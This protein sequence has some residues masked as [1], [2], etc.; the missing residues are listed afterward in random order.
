MHAGIFMGKSAL[1]NVQVDQFIRDGFLRIDRAFS[2]K[3]A[4][5]CC[6]LLWHQIPCDRND[7]VTW[8]NPVI[9]IPLCHGE[10]FDRVT[11]TPVLHEAF[12]LLVGT[13]RWSVRQGL[14]SFIVRF[15]RAEDPLD[16]PVRWHVDASFPGESSDPNEQHDYSAW[17]A[18]VTSRGRALLLLLLF[19]DVGVNDAPTKIRVGSH[20]EVTRLLE[21]AGE[22][23][24]ADADLILDNIGADRPVALATG[25]AG[26]AYLC[27]PFLIHAGQRNCG[28]K[29]RIIAQPPLELQEPYELHRENGNY[30]PVEMSIRR[31]LGRSFG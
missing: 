7:P 25:A 1:G 2:R 18:N 31:A 23:G 29:P 19:S 11:D 5:E 3:L 8:L 10:P 9:R 28:S 20:P 17:R 4:E 26:T 14:G 12:D 15:P 22:Q 27:H 24:I 16:P 13:G 21:P 6:S 30:S